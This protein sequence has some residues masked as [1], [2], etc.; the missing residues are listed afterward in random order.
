MDETY[1]DDEPRS[2][3][4]PG[5]AAGALA[6]LLMLGMLGA[7]WAGHRHGRWHD[8]DWRFGADRTALE[9]LRALSLADADA[10]SLRLV[11]T[12]ADVAEVLTAEQRAELL[13]ALER[14]HHRDR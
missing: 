2:R 5:F 8:R 10:V 7:A 12:V 13:H 6:A 1:E 9:S 11:A 3:F 14:L 4:L